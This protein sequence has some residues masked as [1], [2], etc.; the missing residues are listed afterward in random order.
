MPGTCVPGILNFRDRGELEKMADEVKFIFK[1][2]IKTPVIIMIFYAIFNLLFFF[3][4]YFQMLG[5]SYVVMQTAVE[6]NYLPS[7]ELATL[8]DYIYDMD[9][10]N[11]QLNHCHII[12][13]V[14]DSDSS[15][16]AMVRKG[17]VNGSGSST[18]D[19]VV[20]MKKVQ[21]IRGNAESSNADRVSGISST[22]NALRRKQYGSA[23]VV[24]C[25]ADYTIVWPLRP[26]EQITG[27][28]EAT[29]ATSNV[30]AGMNNGAADSYVGEAELEARRHDSRHEVKLPMHF[31]Y[32]V[33]G[34]KYYPDLAN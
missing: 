25:Y 6:N 31:V 34:L 2:L 13:G 27:Y 30:A 24:G 12:V 1:T 7:A 32:K 21:A 4:I 28:S 11:S 17:L 16:Y 10:R 9:I 20:S 3:Y 23:V 33:P 22:Y 19:V 29:G 14:S 5:F 8:K 18:S 15:D 26:D